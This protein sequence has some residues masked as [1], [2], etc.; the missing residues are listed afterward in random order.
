MKIRRFKKRTLPVFATF[1]AN[2]AAPFT[3]SGKHFNI[4]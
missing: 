2:A 4:N 1:V 3:S